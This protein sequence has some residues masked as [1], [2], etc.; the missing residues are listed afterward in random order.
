M[1][2]PVTDAVTSAGVLPSSLTG[3]QL[4]GSRILYT[5]GGQDPWQWATVRVSD[6]QLLPAIV[7]Q[8]PGCA[9]AVD[10]TTP[11]ATDAPSLQLARQQVREAVAEW[12]SAT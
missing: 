5:N 4:P 7:I 2:A 6:H 1:T 3:T 11:E 9:H 12:L 8:C 10:L